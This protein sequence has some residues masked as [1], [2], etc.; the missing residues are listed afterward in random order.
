MLS[1]A[2]KDFRDLQCFRILSFYF[3]GLTEVDIKYEN[4]KMSQGDVRYMDVFMYA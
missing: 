4:H 2:E 3:K 1:L